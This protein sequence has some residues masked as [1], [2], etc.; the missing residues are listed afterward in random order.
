M[1]FK[2]KK[3]KEGGWSL[4]LWKD[5]KEQ[6][7]PQASWPGGLKPEMTVDEAR[8]VVGSLNSS[9]RI[10][11]DEV[12]KAGAQTR[13]RS[14]KEKACA[15]L[16]ED[17]V[18]AFERLHIESKRSGNHKTFV[19]LVSQWK[20]ARQ[21]ILDVNLDPQDWSLEP[22]PFYKWWLSHPH[23]VDY[24]RRTLSLI[25]KYGVVYSR[26]RGQMFSPIPPLRS[27]WDVQLTEAAL[28]ARLH[29]K[30]P[31]LPEKA[32][33]ALKTKLPLEEYNWLYVAWSFG[34]RPREVDQLTGPQLSPR[35]DTL[36]AIEEEWL[37]VHQDKLKDKVLLWNDRI[38]RIH[39]F[40]KHQKRALE[41]IAG[42][43]LKRPTERRIRGVTG[44]GY[45]LYSC[46]HGFVQ[47]MELIG[48]DIRQ[49]SRWLGHRHL[50]TTE[51]YYKDHSI[52][53]RAKAA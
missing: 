51:K 19:K 18:G 38:K 46:R 45:N 4:R 32:L 9:W 34:L 14:D 39:A 36:W 16:P 37:V 5:G 40:T 43:A 12:A 52:V 47:H 6:Y 15:W 13:V 3:R 22:F 30:L 49:I 41:L 1:H 20:L 53:V 7:V 25:N 44:G 48:Q 17:V 27:P 50:A 33:L 10:M 28:D 35:G 42:Q 11:K 2:V 24:A 29:T 21:I 23:T 26:K 8:V 31:P